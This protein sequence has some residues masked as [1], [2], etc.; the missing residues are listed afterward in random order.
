MDKTRCKISGFSDEISPNFSEQIEGLRELGI[1]YMEIRGVDGENISNL[2]IEKVREIKARLDDAGIRVSSVGSPAGKTLITDDFAFEQ[3]QFDN[4]L[5][6][7]SILEA[8]Y[9]RIFSF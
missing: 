5:E 2:S 9:M 6:K 3:K 1:S 7:A 8:P 4:L